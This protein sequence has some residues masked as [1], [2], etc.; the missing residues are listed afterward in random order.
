MVDRLRFMKLRKVKLPGRLYGQFRGFEQLAKSHELTE[1]VSWADSDR[2]E[3]S[4][5]QGYPCFLTN[6]R[7]D[8]V[9]G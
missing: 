3:S 7:G 2:K 9:I 1:N 5:P 4:E 6:R 8:I